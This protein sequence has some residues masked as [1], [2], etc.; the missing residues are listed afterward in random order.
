MSILFKV[1]KKTPIQIQNLA[2]TLANTNLYR[3][4]HR[5]LYKHYREYY[6]KWDTATKEDINEESNLRLRSF[7]EHAHLNS[8]WYKDKISPSI[9]DEL[10]LNWLPVLEKKTL[11]KT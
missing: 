6:A 3:V 11:F 5:G 9:I 10:N 7:L 8:P 4:R 1:F 2:I